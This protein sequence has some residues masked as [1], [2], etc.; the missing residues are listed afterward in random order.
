MADNDFSSVPNL[1]ETSSKVSDVLDTIQD[2]PESEQDEDLSVLDELGLSPFEVIKYLLIFIVLFGGISFGIY[3][4][5]DWIFPG[6]TAN[7]QAPITPLETNVPDDTNPVVD[8]K[9]IDTEK[10]NLNHNELNDNSL[11]IVST[12][13]PLIYEL[14]ESKLVDASLSNYIRSYRRIRNIY[15]IDLNDYLDASEDRATAYFQYVNQYEAASVDLTFVISNLEKELSY[16]ELV[17]SQVVLEVEEQ[18]SIFFNMLNALED[19]SLNEALNKFQNLS[20]KKTKLT[21]ELKARQAIYNRIADN[22]QAIDKKLEAIKLNK[23]ALVKG[24]TVTNVE[25]VELNLVD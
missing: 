12:S 14:Q 19:S 7:T 23:D 9:A 6:D 13:I 10:T 22:V 16:F 24:V 15:N 21:A 8:P 11:K 2:A 25:G 1:D 17:V 18:E 3:K 4:V 20:I 5:Y